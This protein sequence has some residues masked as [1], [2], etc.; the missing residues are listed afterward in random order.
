MIKGVN[1]A[2]LG[3]IWHHSEPSD[4]PYSLNQFLDRDLFSISYSK[5]V[6]VF[7]GIWIQKKQSWTVF[8][9]TGQ[10]QY[11]CMQN[12]GDWEAVERKRKPRQN[13][14]VVCH[15]VKKNHAI[16][17]L[18]LNPDH[19]HGKMQSFIRFS[20]LKIS[21]KMSTCSSCIFSINNT[22]LKD[23]CYLNEENWEG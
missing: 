20:Y 23:Y 11:T 7:W 5:G 10:T 2:H 3:P 13:Y 9:K 4:I 22:F 15:L 8:G 19:F 17:L 12:D 1:H 14:R 18:V 21:W 16:W 6:L